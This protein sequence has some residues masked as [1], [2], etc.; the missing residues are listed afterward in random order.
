[1]SEYT[2]VEQPIL[3]WLCGEPKAKYGARGVGQEAARGPLVKKLLVTNCS[4]GRH[5]QQSHRS[6]GTRTAYGCG[7]RP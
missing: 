1:M 3:G 5:R 7:A 6:V 2:Y 4:I